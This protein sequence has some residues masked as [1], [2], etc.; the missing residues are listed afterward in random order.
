MTG[1]R[2]WTVLLV[3]HDG[4]HARAVGHRRRGDPGRGA[5]RSCRW[6]HRVRRPQ[7]SRQALELGCC[8]RRGDGRDRRRGGRADRQRGGRREGVRHPSA[9]ELRG[10]GPRR[11]GR[12]RVGRREL[13][14]RFPRLHTIAFTQRGSISASENTWSGVL[15]TPAAFHVAKSYRIA[16]IVDRVGAGDSFAAGLIYA[17]LD[18][19]PL[20]GGPRVRRRRLVPEAFDPRRREPGVRRRGGRA[21]RRLR[22]GAG[23]AVTLSAASRCWSRPSRRGAAPL[24]HAGCRARP[25]DHGGPPRGRGAGDRVHRPRSRR[26][27]SSRRWRRR[28]RGTIRRPSWAPARSATRRRPTGSS[29]PAPGSSWAPASRP[30]SPAC[31]IA[32]ASRTCPA[33]PRPRRS[34]PPRS[35]GSSSSRCSPAT[36]SAP[37]S[38]RR[39]AVRSR[40][41]RS[42]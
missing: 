12:V 40:R 41:R 27:V 9:R 14:E 30:R 20:R 37:P 35:R 28:R 39:S 19:R 5:G 15:W 38:S 26:V 32:G 25:A 8:G 16:P 34:W 36:A 29:H 31:A 21:G 7:L 22:L 1:R 2:S 17:L 18:G 4:H 11:P 3:P 24:L 13:G 6:R 33:A 23:G 42:W 10:G